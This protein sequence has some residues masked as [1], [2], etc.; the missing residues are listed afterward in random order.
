MKHR[1]KLFWLTVLVF[2]L[3]TCSSLGPKSEAQNKEENINRRGL[4][5]QIFQ[6]ENYFVLYSASNPKQKSDLKNTLASLVANSGRDNIRLVDENDL[7]KNKSKTAPL[8]FI[9]VH[10]EIQILKKLG[11]KLP[12]KTAEKN[13]TFNGKALKD[14]SDVFLLSYY[15]NPNNRQYPISFLTANS[16]EALLAFLSKH[17]DILDFGRWGFEHYQNNQRRLMGNFNDDLPHWPVDSSS[18]FQFSKPITAEAN[19]KGINFKL[20]DSN[21]SDLSVRNLADK[22]NETRQLF[23]QMFAIAEP[24]PSIDYEI[25]L[26]GEQKGLSTGNTAPAHIDPSK[27]VAYIALSADQNGAQYH[28]EIKI[29][30]KEILGETPFPMLKEGLPVFFAENWQRKGVLYW[31]HL[32]ARSKSNFSVKNILSEKGISDPSKIVNQTVGAAFCHFLYNTQNSKKFK[33]IYLGKLKGIELEKLQAEWQNWQDNLNAVTERPPTLTKDFYWKGFNFTHE[34][35]QIYNGYLS[36]QA[37]ASLDRLKS[38]GSNSI[39][40]VPYSFMRN[41]KQPSAFPIPDRAGSENDASIVHSIYHAHQRGM[42]VLLKPQVWIG[43]NSWPGDVEMQSEKE[44]NQFFEFYYR[45]IRH[46]ALMA[47]MHQVEALCL[48]VE[49]SKATLQHPEKWVEII[50]E[51]RNIYHGPITYSANWGE[52]FEKLTFWDELDYIGI[53]CYYPLTKE[54]RPTDRELIKGF[55]SNLS[56]IE[57]TAKKHKKQVLLTEIGFRSITA[58]W[59]QP[60]DYPGEQEADQRSQDRCYKIVFG[61]LKNEKWCKGIFWWKWPTTFERSDPADKRFI[62][63]NKAAEKTVKKWYSKR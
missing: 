26:N 50:R 44:W 38:L 19:V 12:L 42:K 27:H 6:S 59:V 9:G 62:P 14:S 60:H 61:C 46:Y 24:I 45:W 34:G 23:K 21:I 25:F 39:T 35:Y 32:L 51:I 55:E 20:H 28:P 10:N 54:E 22:L 17:Q 30:A 37:E 58:P 29:W 7:A 53:S 11:E 3:N 40:L 33:Q 8:L 47:S 63:Y 52:E 48:G 5:R 57:K 13:I 41:P 49:F 15:P 16:H 36:K 56:K 2:S 1:L 43:R 4:I 18:I 31:F